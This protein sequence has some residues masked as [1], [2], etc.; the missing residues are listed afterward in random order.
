MSMEKVPLDSEVKIQ[1]A[2]NTAKGR[3]DQLLALG[4]NYLKPATVTDMNNEF[5]DYPALRILRNTAD[6]VVDAKEELLEVAGEN[7]LNR[8]SWYFN[9]LEGHVVCKDNP[10]AVYALF[11]LDLSGNHPMMNTPERLINAGDSIRLGNVAMIAGGYVVNTGFTA[12]SVLSLFNI[13]KPLFIDKNAKKALA[14]IAEVNFSA[15]EEQVIA[16]LD[17]IFEAVVDNNHAMTEPQLRAELALWGF[18]YQPAKEKT[19]IGGDIFLPDGITKA[20]GAEVRIGKHFNTNGKRSKE[21]VKVYADAN[22]HFSAETTIDGDT[23]INVRILNCADN[24]PAIVIEPATNQ[25]THVIHM[26]AGTSSL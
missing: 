18:H 17:V 1:M 13:Y 16:T 21:G 19:V 8:N 24:S 9:E 5:V 6:S 7:L 15:K 23:F 25:L 14:G 20:A 4:T 12:A 3:Y 22:G 11:D 26:I 10:K 2:L